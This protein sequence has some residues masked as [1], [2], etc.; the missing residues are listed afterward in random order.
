V[1]P[2][3]ALSAEYAPTQ[4]DEALRARIARQLA[5]H[6]RRA[7]APASE[8]PAAVAVVLVPG[9]AGEPSFLLT[10]RA[11]DLAHHAGQFALPGGRLEGQESHEQAARRELAEELGVSL[12]AERVLG[13]L[14]DYVTFSG[15]VITPVVLWGPDVARL[16][17]DPRE[18]AIAYRVP[19]AQLFQPIID[20]LARSAGGELGA[21]PAL[22]AAGRASATAPLLALPLLGTHIYS[23]T[24]AIIYQFR[25]LGLLGRPTP[26]QHFAQPEFAR[27]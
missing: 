4:L 21:S 24:A 15:F 16:S 13:L 26:V 27:R 3:A 14:D 6:T 12:G 11:G 10:R 23:P 22:S 1:T 20:Q 8:R 5:G 2:A 19:L 17:P 18:V 25:E 9:E 7:L